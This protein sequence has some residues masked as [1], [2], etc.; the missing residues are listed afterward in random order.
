MNLKSGD[1]IK[2]KQAYALFEIVKDNFNVLPGGEQIKVG[3][4]LSE[5]EY[6][7]DAVFKIIDIVC[8]VR[9]TAYEDISMPS[10]ILGSGKEEKVIARA[11]CYKA[12]KNFLYL[13]DTKIGS[14]F[15]DR[16]RITIYLARLAI[17]RDLEI[18]YD[19]RLSDWELIC[20]KI[21]ELNK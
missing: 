10:S 3:K 18:N 15:G 9:N 12:I 19:G 1:M 6:I 17:N 11:L 4:L 5:I 20:D 8:D 14:L 16:N 2:Q 7:D 21:S 13:S